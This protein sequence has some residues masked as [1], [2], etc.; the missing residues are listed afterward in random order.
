VVRLERLKVSGVRNLDPLDLTLPSGTVWLV[1]PNGAGKTSVLEAIYVLSR[2]S[3]FRGRR[4][5]PLTSRGQVCARVE[6]WLLDG[7]YCWEQRWTSGD[8]QQT[9]SAGPGF[10]V[11]LVGSSMHALVEGDPALRRRF[12]DWNLF[13]VEPQ[14]GVLRQRYRR[15]ASQRNAW[16]KAGGSGRA[17]WDPEFAAVLTKVAHSR[18]QFFDRLASAFTPIAANFD[19]T[20]GLT[21]AWRGGLPSGV[22]DVAAWLDEHRAADV[23]RGYSFLSPARADFVMLKDGVPWAGSRGQNKLAGILLQIAADSVVSSTLGRGAVWLVDDLAAELDVTSQVAILP[24]LRQAADQLIVT[25][26]MEP[27]SAATTD[28]AIEVFHVEQGRVEAWTATVP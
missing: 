18:R 27:P 8:R 20:E 9:R 3:S 11:R 21:P 10:L 14:F 25:G 17:V 28:C 4:H 19:A 15:V 16:L 7:E 24:L 23:G 12:V 13:H 1:G 22:D 5:G 26:L 2:G 6:G